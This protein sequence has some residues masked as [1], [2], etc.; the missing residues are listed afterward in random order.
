[1]R[2]ALYR[3]SRGSLLL[4]LVLLLISVAAWE[5]SVGAQETPEEVGSGPGFVT[6][7]D[8]GV[9]ADGSLVVIDSGLEAVVRVDPVSGDRTI[10]SDAG[11]GSGTAFE[12]PLGIAVEADGS[13]VVIDIGL[14]AVLRVDPVTGD[15]TIHSDATTGVDIVASASA[16]APEPVAEPPAT[17]GP[18]Y[19]SRIALA[20]LLIGALLVMS[21]IY[22]LRGHSGRARRRHA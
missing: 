5:G 13:L 7:F 14:L 12:S 21:G 22:I 17:G 3:L 20:A 8:I 19:I 16:P 10:V 9:E 4:A 2:N 15:R 11:T 1:M 18:T 6:P